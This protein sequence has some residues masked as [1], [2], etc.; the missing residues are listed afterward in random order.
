[1][2][3]VRKAKITAVVAKK[4]GRASNDARLFEVVTSRGD[5]S[6]W[7]QVYERV[8]EIEQTHDLRVKSITVEDQ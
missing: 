8:R 1:M 3:T 7:V 6:F 4:Q 5:E 2:P